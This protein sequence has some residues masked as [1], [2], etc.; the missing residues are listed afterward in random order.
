[1]TPNV[2]IVHIHNPYWR[3]CR[4]WIPLFLLW[5]P[6]ILIS[7]LILLV[8]LVVCLGLQISFWSAVAVLWGIVCSLPGTN[9]HVR[10]DGTQ[11]QVRVI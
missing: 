3:G 11:V 7:P 6:V 9:V 10:A 5:I 4:L 2:A 1:M 8:L